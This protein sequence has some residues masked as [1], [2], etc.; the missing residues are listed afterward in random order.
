[1]LA[2][3]L[4]ASAAAQDEPGVRVDVPTQ[5]DAWI[6]PAV[7]RMQ[8]RPVRAVTFRK[9]DRPGGSSRPLPPEV[10]EPWL[11]LLETRVGAAFEARKASADC[12]RLWSDR[13]LV[14]AAYAA[15]VD[16]G[17]AV[18]FQIELEVE[19][20]AGV[21]FV[22]MDNLDRATADAL[23]GLYPGRQVSRTEAE[24]MRKV[25][26]ARYQRDGYAFCSVG[27]EEL[28]LPDPV[29]GATRRSL[30]LRTLRFVVDEGPKVTVRDIVFRGNASFIADPVLGFLGT[31]DY[32]LR[33]ARLAS[34]PARGLING[35]PFSREILDED[36]D[37]LRLFYRSRGFLDATVDV[38]DVLFTPDRRQV[39]LQIVV[40]EGPR[41]R[42]RSVRVEHVDEGTRQPLTEPPL[43]PIEEL[44]QVLKVQPGEFYS[45][46]RLQRDV[47]ALEDFYGSR[48]HPSRR[49]PGM[50]NVPKA[51]V[52]F[53]PLETFAETPEVDIV[54]QV[55]EGTPKRLRDIAIRGNRFTRDSVIRRRFRVFPGDTIDMV[56][57]RRSLRSIESTRYF[58]DPANMQAPRLQLEPVPGETDLV[59]IGL[60][61]ADGPTGRLQW[62]AGISTGQG[63]QAQ[64][65]FAKNNFDLWKPPSSLNPITAIGEIIDS[66][67]FHGGGQDLNLLLAPGTRYSQFQIT[68]R[69]PD[70]FGQHLDTWELRVNGRRTI[71]RLTDGY[72]SDVLGADV[73]LSRNFTD[74]LNAGLAVRQESVEID[75]LAADATSLAYAFEGQTELRGLRLTARYRDYDDPRRPTSGFELGA[76]AEVVGGPLGGEE[77]LTKFTHSAHLWVPLRENESGHR[78]VLHLEQFLGFANAFGGSDDV[79]LTERFYL[80]GANLRGFEPRRAG[81][82]QFGRPLGG[83]AIWTMTQELV[84]PLVPTR[85]EGDVRDRELVRGVIFHDLGLLGLRAD[86][87]TFRELRGSWGI[88]VRIEIPFL[89]IPIAIDLGWPYRYE[90]SDDRRQLFFTIS[91]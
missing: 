39:D 86:D 87:P 22:G 63:V 27:I 38:A 74:N 24:A 88:G 41:Y 51:C 35:G 44:Q 61:V 36:L 29:P 40:V 91:R 30:L 34:G 8:G 64:I 66:K 5:G 67:A 55:S 14:V 49:F 48:G 89:E 37:R 16:D 32:L 80:G 42:I 23:L 33:D 20:F 83:E 65:T 71:R 2:L 4:M 85:L 47:Q 31:E 69:E 52:V 78:T 77:S 70:V 54:F 90:D 58:H 60:D 72:T 17:I 26:L 3:V 81:P 10:V 19:V 13:R 68:F 84:F 28:P 25:L 9:A 82:K 21:E 43:Y 46:D 45:F 73:G 50:S 79:F 7:E 57:V 76:A 12:L 11:L 56:A 15:E 53:S 18:A 59:D 6:D 1:M 62:G 75:D